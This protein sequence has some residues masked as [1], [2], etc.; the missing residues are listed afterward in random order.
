M[1]TV[2]SLMGKS[3]KAH[4]GTK[5]KFGK[6]KQFGKKMYVKAHPGAKVKFK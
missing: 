2:R 6:G 4:P 5:V 1:S 3:V